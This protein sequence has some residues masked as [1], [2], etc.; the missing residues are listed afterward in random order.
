VLAALHDLRA[1]FDEKPQA[2][3]A[4]GDAN[5]KECQASFTAKFKGQAIKGSILCGVGDN[6]AA[7]SIIYDR[8]DAPTA[9]LATLMAA[10]PTGTKWV[11][12]PLA[13]GS[14]TIQ[15]PADW[16]LK[17]STQLGSVVAT[18]P[19]GQEIGLGV[20]AEVVD[21]HSF[22]AAQVRA[23]GTMLVAPY[24]D[25][26]TA[27]RNLAPQ[28]S[29]M[30][31]RAG[32]PAITLDKI[33]SS[34]PAQAQIPGAQAAWITCALTKGTGPQ[35]V[36]AREIVLLEC[37]PLGQ[38][39]WGIYTSYALAP[40]SNYDRD[41]PVMLQIANSWKLND[42]VVM[43]NSRQMINAQNRSFAAF[44]NSM[45]EKSAAFDSYM[46]SVRNSERVRERSNADFDEVIRGYRTVEDTQTGDRRDV[47]LGY[48]KEIVDKL[49]EH[50]GFERY[51]EIPLRDQ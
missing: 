15:L 21:P 25:P 39:A 2:S 49:N 38:W 37:Y 32:G 19:N 9:E 14:G 1:V 24:S 22:I 26:V 4:F 31:Q 35:A 11:Q 28:I 42:S 10:L 12:H 47:N 17:Q 20:G 51:K 40:E 48:S 27:L 3:G 23:N 8:A 46:A 6:G 36:K 41:L 30:S 43:D 34:S 16:T 44:E 7:I 29:S 5:D 50:A 13:G 45:K 18:G 33:I